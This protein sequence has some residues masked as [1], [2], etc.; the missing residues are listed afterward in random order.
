MP[1]RSEGC[2]QY[3]KHRFSNVKET[4]GGELRT[5]RNDEDRAIVTGY[6]FHSAI[7][8][9]RTGTSKDI[10]TNSRAQQSFAHKSCK[11]RL[12]PYTT[13]RQIIAP[14]YRTII[15]ERTCAS[16]TDGANLA[17]VVC[18]INNSLDRWYKRQR[19]MSSYK[20]FQGFEHQRRMVVENVAIHSKMIK[21]FGHRSLEP[22][23]LRLETS[24]DLS[25]D[26]A[27]HSL[28]R[29]KALVHAKFRSSHRRFYGIICFRATD[30]TARL[31]RFL[32]QERGHSTLKKA[33]R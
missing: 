10:S 8:L 2:L 30:V 31:P 23:V 27:P 20:S 28:F 5:I 15:A 14:T 11:A 4:D 9:S 1:N 6:G 21:W 25:H 22:L 13:S 3:L 29:I 26:T 33:A 32:R 17:L 24:A 7:H 12:M 19:W 16:A 18:S